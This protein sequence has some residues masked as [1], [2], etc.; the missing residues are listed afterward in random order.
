MYMQNNGV[1]PLMEIF[2][3]WGFGVSRGGALPLFLRKKGGGVLNVE[4]KHGK[5]SSLKMKQR[6]KKTSHDEHREVFN[7]DEKTNY[8]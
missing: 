1:G 8:G 3:Q 6:P 5:R 4:I 2:K 7:T